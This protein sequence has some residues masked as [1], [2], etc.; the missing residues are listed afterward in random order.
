MSPLQIQILTTS[1][2]GKTCTII[3]VKHTWAK[4]LHVPQMKISSTWTEARRHHLVFPLH[5]SPAAFYLLLWSLT[6]DMALQ[7]MAIQMYLLKAQHF[8][9]VLF[10]L[11]H[12]PEE[13]EKSCF[14]YFQVPKVK[15]NCLVIVGQNTV[16][17]TLLFYTAFK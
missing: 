8:F 5:N 6:A 11:P 15:R 13:M 16:F 12:L 7:R 9:F 2:I 4:F 10:F 17:W 3:Q 14:L 1:L